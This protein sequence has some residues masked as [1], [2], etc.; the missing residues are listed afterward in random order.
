MII[1]RN[2]NIDMYIKDLPKNIWEKTFSD[3]A[4]FITYVYNEGLVTEYGE[5]H[6]SEVS[7]WMKND[8]A[9]AKALPRSDF[10]NI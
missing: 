3:I 10:I 1:L 6:S 7:E 8:L 2:E 4:E 9:A 5:I